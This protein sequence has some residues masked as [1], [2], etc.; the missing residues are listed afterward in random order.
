MKKLF[1]SLLSLLMV[2][3]LIMP[4]SAEDSGDVSDTSYEAELILADGTMQQYESLVDAV[5]NAK[6]GSTVK[7]LRDVKTSRSIN[8]TQ[9]GVTIDL[10]GHNVDGSEMSSKGDTGVI[11]LRTT[12]GAKPVEGIPNTLSLINSANTGGEVIG[13]L[14]V[15]AK[16]GNSM[17]EL[18]INIGDTVT[19]KTLE[20]GSDSVKLATSAY[21]I[22]SDKNASYFHNGAYSVEDDQGVKR[23]YGTFANCVKVANGREITLLNDYEG[24][25]G[26]KSGS[27]NAIL[28]LNGHTYTYT[29]IK[30]S[31]IDVNYPN[32]TL[33]IKDGNLQSL[34]NVNGAELVGAENQKD[35]RGLVLENVE[36]TVNGNGVYGI[37]TNG[38]ESG[39]S[40][41][42]KNS[43]L[44][45]LDGFGIYFPSS[46]DVT[47]DN[48]TINAKYVGVQL[49]AGNLTIS[50]DT[51]INTTAAPS[52]KQENDGVI[53]DGAAISIIDREGYQGIG[54]VDIQNGTFKADNSDALKAYRFNNTDKAENVWEEAGEFVSIT[55]GT[56]SD[57]KAS[58]YLIDNNAF[59]KNDNNLY[60]ITD[61]D[62]LRVS[63]AI[64]VKDDN[65]EYYI[66]AGTEL[67]DDV[68]EVT[69]E[70]VQLHI[71][72]NDN[73]EDIYKTVELEGY[74][75][76]DVL[77]V[78]DIDVAS[79][80]DAKDSIPEFGKIF[81]NQGE[82]KYEIKEELMINGWTHL[83]VMITDY[84]PVNLW[85]V[86]NKDMSTKE[87]IGTKNAKTDEILA[88]VAKEILEN[89]PYSIKGYENDGVIYKWG[90]EEPIGGKTVVGFNKYEIFV[91]FEPVE[92]TITLDLDNGK[93]PEGS[94]NPIKYTIEDEMIT[95]PIP[96]RN[97]FFFEGWYDGDTLVETIDPKE[98]LKDMT[99]TASW[100]QKIANSI[101]Y[102]A[103]G[104]TGGPV[105]NFTNSSTISVKKDAPSRDGYVFV[106][107]NTKADGTG[108]K[109]MP[110]ESF[111]IDPD[112]IGGQKVILYAMWQK[113]E[114]KP[115]ISCAGV[116]DTNCDGV[117]TCEEEKGEGWTWN[118]TT[119]VCE[120]T[121][122]T[123]YTVVNTAA[124]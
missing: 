63:D 69:P 52:Q 20:D 80:Y 118:N 47:I 51:S 70:R 56:F 113:E 42:L 39:N 21:I 94:T 107:W 104:G 97:G 1:I 5:K 117:V 58:E 3:C 57:H 73:K 34:N 45:V 32:V 64:K 9:Y 26:I 84:Y 120:F 88:D 93:L 61:K 82:F 123:G 16:C 121:G 96:T 24:G 46:G 29:G 81:I 62:T 23:I 30:N 105:N 110:G 83:S 122:S 102:D 28:N 41:K 77:K 92:Y 114:T 78:F 89:N 90:L 87:L 124:K 12:Y 43:T 116:K 112:N 95:L 72:R 11:S 33:T 35:N 22:Y 18:P 91:N 106:G 74:Y 49:C 85:A 76:G 99:L 13:V 119:K 8:N 108:I 59:F 98:T 100:R 111:L 71:Y 109:Y 14:P 115:S 65:G 48:S 31:M 37:V 50:N 68:Q 55:S 17:I 10:N 4:I 66:P 75:K 7:L 36:M 79:Y 60:V 54:K 25:E 86:T 67:P 2:C 6:T 103:N 19:L 44:N 15:D 38:T 101:Q 53:S 40:I 27:R